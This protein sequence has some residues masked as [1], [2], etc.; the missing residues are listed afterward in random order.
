MNHLL[1]SKIIEYRNYVPTFLKKKLKY[2]KK[3]I[4]LAE[5]AH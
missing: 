3:I 5:T 2:I 4:E 1:F